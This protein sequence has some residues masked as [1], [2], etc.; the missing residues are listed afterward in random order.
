MLSPDGRWVACVSNETWPLGVYVM[1]LDGGTRY[2]SRRQAAFFLLGAGTVANFFPECRQ[3]TDGG[4]GEGRRHFHGVRACGTVR[5]VLGRPPLPD[6]GATAS[7]A[8]RSAACGCVPPPPP[9]SRF[10]SCTECRSVLML[11][12]PA[13]AGA[14][15]HA[16]PR[17][18][19]MTHSVASPHSDM[20]RL[21][22]VRHRH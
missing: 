4:R 17:R 10:P 9:P 12:A 1:P 18:R 20:R 14:V 16:A 22:T 2:R 19:R 11:A 15:P 8:T 7:R 3:Q 21:R 6:N 13:G 5:N